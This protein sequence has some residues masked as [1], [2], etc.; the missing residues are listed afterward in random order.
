MVRTS[1]TKHYARQPYCRNKPQKSTPVN[2]CVF[3]MAFGAAGSTEQLVRHHNDDLNGVEG[4]ILLGSGAWTR[5]PSNQRRC[6]APA[7]PHRAPS[8]RPPPHHHGWHPVAPAQLRAV[9]SKPEPIPSARRQRAA[10]RGTQRAPGGC[11]PSNCFG[12]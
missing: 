5:T 7:A 12:F 8:C 3:P 1:I 2:F 9:L 11:V 10:T 6:L 4:L